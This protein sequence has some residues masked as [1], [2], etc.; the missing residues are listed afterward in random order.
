MGANG[1]G[2]TQAASAST[3]TTTN[4]NT[5]IG[6]QPLPDGTASYFDIYGSTDVETTNYTTNVGFWPSGAVYGTIKGIVTDNDTEG[7]FLFTRTD[8]NDNVLHA[9]EI[10][11]GLDNTQ[12]NDT[13]IQ[14]IANNIP[15]TTDTLVSSE[16]GVISDSVNASGSLSDNSVLRPKNWARGRV[17]IH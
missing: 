11:T 8:L 7:C 12:T 4:L 16:S 3:Q 2:S 15:T 17:E 9:T 1:S 14:S 6:P 5:L 10:V 13:E